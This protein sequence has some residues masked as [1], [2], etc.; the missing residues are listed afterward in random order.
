MTLRIVKI[1]TSLL[2][3][4]EKR[5]T[6]EAI[7][8]FSTTIS[9]SLKRKE[10][11]ILVTS[12][13]VGLGCQCLDL[14]QRPEDLLSLQAAA[15]IGQGKLMALYEAAMS[16][17]GYKVAQVL[18]TRSDLGSRSRYKNAS[19]TLQK[20]LEWG[21]IPI[22]NE[23]DTLSPEELRYGD[24]DTLSALVAAAVNADQLIL[25][26][27]IDKL[28]SADPKTN[29]EAKPITDVHNH[30][31]L[32]HLQEITQKS[33]ETSW[34]T[35]GIRT[36]LIAASI[37]TTSGI[38]VHIADGR[39]PKVLKRLLEGGRGGTVFHPSTKPLRSQKSWLAH[40]LEPIGKLE[41]DS[42]AWEAIKNN[43]A[44]LLLVGVTN[45]EGHFEANQPVKL[46][47]PSGQEFARGLCSISSDA[48]REALPIKADSRTSPV[49]IHRDVLVLLNNTL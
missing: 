19:K 22:I 13:A 42:G 31:E 37:A 11:I 45:I 41:V 32:I 35:G 8:S 20:L 24:N 39:N 17:E 21:V 14:N 33:N 5:S 36:K 12:G 1:G 10:Q 28:Y 3:A 43:G 29:S 48:I 26:T 4:T 30:R 27:D 23:N 6:A 44:S 7:K 38:T 15:A 25:L 18:L 47:N 9:E 16:E 2:R 34:G 49:V 46:L 40:A